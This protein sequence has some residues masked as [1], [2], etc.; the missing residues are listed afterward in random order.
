[1]NG[2]RGEYTEEI[3]HYYSESLE[4]MYRRNR[5]V[6]EEDFVLVYLGGIWMKPIHFE[7]ADRLESEIVFRDA[8]HDYIRTSSDYFR[9]D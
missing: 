2:R 4:K 7:K 3:D 6:F 5:R 9:F 1:M 8:V